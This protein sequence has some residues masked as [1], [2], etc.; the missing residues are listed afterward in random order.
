MNLSSQLYL[1]IKLTIYL[2]LCPYHIPHFFIFTLLAWV[3]VLYY[4]L[5]TTRSSSRKCFNISSN[6]Y[7]GPINLLVCSSGGVGTFF[8]WSRLYKPPPP[9]PLWIL[10]ISYSWQSKAAS[11]D[12]FVSYEANRAPMWRTGWGDKIMRCEG[13]ISGIKMFSILKKNE[14]KP[15]FT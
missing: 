9:S 8:G 5:S 6:V 2:S 11:A 14:A 3:F 10:V 13:E 1:S 7:K 4:L 12:F 15:I